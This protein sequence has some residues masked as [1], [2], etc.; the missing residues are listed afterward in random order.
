[1]QKQKV[2]HLY[3]TYCNREPNYSIYHAAWQ[4]SHSVITSSLPLHYIINYSVNI[5]VIG[6]SQH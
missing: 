3:Y 5:R 2:S 4:H 1:M 6:T